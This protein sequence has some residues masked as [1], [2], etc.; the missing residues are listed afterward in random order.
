MPGNCNVSQ[1]KLDKD[2][3]TRGQEKTTLFTVYVYPFKMV[4]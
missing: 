3:E 2:K 1:I 4:K